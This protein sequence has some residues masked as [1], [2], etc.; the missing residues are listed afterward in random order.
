MSKGRLFFLFLTAA[1]MVLNGCATDIRTTKEK[2]YFDITKLFPQGEVIRSISE[3]GLEYELL[4]YPQE[5]EKEKFALIYAHHAAGWDGNKMMEFLEED[6]RAR[7]FMVLAPTRVKSYG[8]KKDEF[9]EFTE[10]LDEVIKHYP[11]DPDQVYLLGVSAGT[12]VSGWLARYEPKKWKG[13]ALTASVPAAEWVEPS[14]GAEYPPFLVIHGA[15]DAMFVPERIEAMVS[16]MKAAKIETYYF[17]D[18]NA[19]HQYKTDWGNGILTWM[20]WMA[21]KEKV[22]AHPVDPAE[23]EKMIKDRL[24][25]VQPPADD[26]SAIS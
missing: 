12:W 10:L 13:V 16:K 22:G 24:G 11:V 18:E 17:L 21:R 5:T 23:V 14:K 26:H 3:K 15:Q 20:D 7:R 1:G 4:A 25:A 2:P 9:K 6:A 19:V 8:S